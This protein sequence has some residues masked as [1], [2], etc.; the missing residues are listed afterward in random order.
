MSLGEVKYLS[1][2]LQEMFLWA[3]NKKRWKEE[4][5]EGQ[6]SIRGEGRQGR[7]LGFNANIGSRAETE[8]ER[9]TGHS[10]KKKSNGEKGQL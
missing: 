8:K 3:Q 9:K 7:S 2:Y 6:K 5:E 1:H 4:A 10:K